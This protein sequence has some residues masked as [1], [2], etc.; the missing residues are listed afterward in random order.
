MGNR[1]KNLKQSPCYQC[2]LQDECIKKCKKINEYWEIVDAVMPNADFNYK[3]CPLWIVLNI[4]KEREK[5]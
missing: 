5:K 1:I 2:G 3:E 4:E